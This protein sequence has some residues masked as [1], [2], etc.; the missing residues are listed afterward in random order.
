[1]GFGGIGQSGFAPGWLATVGQHPRYSQPVDPRGPFSIF[2]FNA[3]TH[4]NNQFYLYG[5]P[6][7]FKALVALQ[8]PHMFWQVYDSPPNPAYYSHPPSWANGFSGRLP[9]GHHHGGYA[10]TG[11]RF[12]RL[13]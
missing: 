4:S 3:T 6:E 7:E 11:Q 1:M 5:A 2:N 13:V 12:N 9:G 8:D 10:I